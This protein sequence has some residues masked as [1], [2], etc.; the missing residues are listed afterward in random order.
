[1]SA[2]D[3]LKELVDWLNKEQKQ[4]DYSYA[5]RKHYSRVL[6]RINELVD[7]HLKGEPTDV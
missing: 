5:D 6:W 2:K 3:V 4:E 7:D 1:M